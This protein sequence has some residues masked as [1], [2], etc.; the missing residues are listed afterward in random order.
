ML[1]KWKQARTTFE[2]ATNISNGAKKKQKRWQDEASSCHDIAVSFV[3]PLARNN[4]F[5]IERVKASKASGKKRR[6]SSNGLNADASIENMEPILCV[7]SSHRVA[8]LGRSSAASG[9]TLSES[10]SRN[11]VSRPGYSTSF[12][13]AT[14]PH[15]TLEGVASCGAQYDPVSNLLYAIRNGGEL[16]IWTASSSS[17]IQG[18]DQTLDDGKDTSLNDTASQNTKKRKEPES[19]ASSFDRIISERLNFPDGMV[20]VTLNPFYCQEQQQLSAIGASGC[21]HD[22]SIWV[23][24]SRDG[25]SSFDLLVVDGSSMASNG[26]VT[27]KKGRSKKD[28]GV[29]VNN[30]K[31]LDSRARR[32][33]DKG[34]GELK[35]SLMIK[36]QS[37]L[38]N[39]DD[40]RVILRQHH[41]RV[42]VV[43]GKECSHLVNFATHTILEVSNKDDITAN[44]SGNSLCIVHTNENGGCVLSSVE[45][46]RGDKEM[47]G[48]LTSIT[49]KNK[50]EKKSSLFSFGCVGENLYAMLSKEKCQPS[51]SLLSTLRILDI[52]RK[53]ELLVHSWKEGGTGG[54]DISPTDAV[55]TKML[56][57]KRCHA[58]ITNELDG[59]LV[60]I[61]STRTGAIGVISSTIST[62]AD[63]FLLNDESS[64]N[65]S[66]L[67]LALRAVAASESLPPDPSIYPKDDESVKQKNVDAAVDLA[68]DE[69][70]QVAGS[71]LHFIEGLGDDRTTNSG[72]GSKSKEGT[73]TTP[74]E[75]MSWR[76]A[77]DDGKS[78]IKNANDVD[79]AS[80]HINGLMNGIN[81]KS[82][83]QMNQELSEQPRR[84]IAAAFRHTFTLLLSIHKTAKKLSG[85]DSL[86][87]EKI[88]QESIGVLSKV[89]RSHCLQSRIDCDINVSGGGN[90]FIKLFRSYPS[91]LLQNL[92][93][94]RIHSIGAL[95]ILNDMLQHVT[96]LSESLLVYMIRFLM[97]SVGVNDATAYYYAK[98]S[99][100][101]KKSSKGYKLSKQ[102]R[103][104]SEA[105]SETD[106]IRSQAESK[107]LAEAVLDFSSKIVTYSKCNPSLLSKSMREILT[108]A[109]VEPFLA[110]LSKLLK[111]CETSRW[112]REGSIGSSLCVRVID[113]ISSLTEAHSGTILKISDEGSLVV[114]RI[115][116]DI[117]AVVDQTNAANELMELS[118]RITDGFADPKTT[119]FSDDKK[120]TSKSKEAPIFI[121]AY[122]IERLVF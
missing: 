8:L 85:N 77:F 3:K 48:S 97:R 27:E 88:R 31:L 115:Q 75:P 33:F 108:A 63:G 89:L 117:Q 10:K 9:A 69:L 37:V 20:P 56:H 91:V 35:N 100:R 120:A 103:H 57:D 84:Y 112:Q 96:D 7:T 114:N 81:S 19:T 23:A 92:Q 42:S 110:I 18:P 40:G 113:W 29:V 72:K 22:G 46:S 43:G 90:A 25:N 66:S 76:V 1:T 12:D 67:V 28:N 38:L 2:Y 74:V 83:P 122:T 44:I 13:V 119:K 50:S 107:L 68:C 45:L 106:N 101:A 65:T 87:L 4:P 80:V 79:T 86:I 62:N 5:Y 26:K 55:L 32:S 53:V 6:K 109:E 73:T 24:I 105:T 58:M 94:E 61:T 41:I 99:S 121:A 51:G 60:L 36:V 17:V 49:L 11:Y 16:V 15:S 14:K 78:K 21:C 102:L 71:I 59:S 52:R 39:Q 95:H 118:G 70:N 30:W 82:K 111:L 54:V 98:A 47:A 64:S 34:S 93:N 104:S 116:A